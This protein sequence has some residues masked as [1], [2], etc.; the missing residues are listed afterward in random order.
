MIHVTLHTKI[1]LMLVVVAF[2]C[3]PQGTMLLDVVGWI[4]QVQRGT[5]D[6]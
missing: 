5:S 2:K 6:I 4:R 1:E 3:F